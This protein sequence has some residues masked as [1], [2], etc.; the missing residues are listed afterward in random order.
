LFLT[1]LWRASRV[2]YRITG[3]A[4]SLSEKTSEVFVATK[5]LRDSASFRHFVC[6]ESPDQDF[7]SLG[8]RSLRQAARDGEIVTP[9]WGFVKRFVGWV[10]SLGRISASTA[11]PCTTP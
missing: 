4:G 8:S 2:T 5:A 3:P 10:G 9:G 1:R 11:G 7:R 6:L